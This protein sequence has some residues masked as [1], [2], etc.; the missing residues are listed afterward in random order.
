MFS[1]PCS[2][3][4]HLIM[5][6]QVGDGSNSCL[7]GLRQD[8]RHVDLQQLT[9]QFRTAKHR[10]IITDYDGTLTSETDSKASI[11][12]STIV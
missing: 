10:I 6:L 8:F 1:L 9:Y 2:D 4:H 5:C 11:I 7:V 12:S 3:E